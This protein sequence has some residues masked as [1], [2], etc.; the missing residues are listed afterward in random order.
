MGRL[1][2]TFHHEAKWM[3]VLSLSPVVL[4]L[5]VLIVIWLLR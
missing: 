4:G 1:G 5:F 2:F 3:M